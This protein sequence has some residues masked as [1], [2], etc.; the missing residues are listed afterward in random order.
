M[1]HATRTPVDAGKPAQQVVRELDPLRGQIA[2]RERILSRQRKARG[3]IVDDR[4]RERFKR[5]LQREIE[6]HMTEI[7]TG[8]KPA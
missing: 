4:L 1:G 2:Q 7:M 5:H 3:P 6:R 8:T